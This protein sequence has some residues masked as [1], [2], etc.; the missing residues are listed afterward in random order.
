MG[1]WGKCR[2][3]FTSN[4]RKRWTDPVTARRVPSKWKGEQGEQGEQGDNRVHNHPSYVYNGMNA[5]VNDTS[6]TLHN[7]NNQNECC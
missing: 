1:R 5:V 3:Q 2:G 7:N 6:C 4:P